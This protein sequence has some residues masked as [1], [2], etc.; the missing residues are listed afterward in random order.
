M[1]MAALQNNL[2]GDVK[3]LVAKEGK[4]RLRVG[5]FRGCFVWRE[6]KSRC[7]L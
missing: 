2:S 1:K 3:K 6:I 5:D 4:Y 7:I